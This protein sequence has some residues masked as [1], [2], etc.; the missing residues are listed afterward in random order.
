M[1]RTGV[2]AGAGALFLMSLGGSALA[3]SGP[4]ATPPGSNV[5]APLNMST[6]FQDKPGGIWFDGGLGVNSGS[7]LCFGSS[8]ITSW[9]QAVAS[10]SL[11]TASGT[12]IYNN[13]TGNVGIGTTSP[14]TLLTLE[15]SNAAAGLTLSRTGALTGNWG[16]SIGNSNNT[17][18]FNDNV[19]NATRLVLASN[20]NVGIGTVSPGA[21]A[22]MTGGLTINGTNSTQL[23]IQKNGTTG[24]A[25]NVGDTT[26]GDVNFYDK[27]G[28]TFTRSITLNKGNV[29]IGTANPNLLLTT[30]GAIFSQSTGN[31]AGIY[32]TAGNGSYG[33]LQATNAANN[34]AKNLILQ[35]FGGSVAIGTTNPLRPLEV[36]NAMRFTN[37]SADT[38]DGVIGTA[39]FLAGL[40][41]V[42]INTDG[43]GRKINEW[44]SIIQ[45]E[46]PAGNV[47]PG[48]T[49]INTANFGT[50]R[51]PLVVSEAGGWRGAILLRNSAENNTWNMLV[52]Y[53]TGDGKFV[54]VGNAAVDEF[55]LDQSG[56]VYIPGTLTQGS[57]ERLKKNVAT[58][59]D[60]SGLSAVDK[61][62]PVSF[63]WI[64]PSQASS[65]QLG[66]I[67]QQV[68]T[69]FPG[70]VTRES[71]T[72]YTPDGTL[73]VNY[74][75]LIA[76]LVKSVQELDAKVS[77]QQQE[78]DQL[79]AEVQALQAK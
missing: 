16:I 77:V 43:A 59:D 57:D 11:W 71:S 30:E 2:F 50:A 72:T 41:I 32:M 39:P 38:N 12:N 65:T 19:A 66:F 18:N 7:A 8:C 68:Q 51:A 61:L 49:L 17:L 31:D 55:M 22:G 37:S 4:S 63:N 79:K 76:P 24:L 64:D 70:L 26:A 53:A 78:I 74:N 73:S 9:A 46:N 42:G 35:Q 6:T 3:W 15:G 14:Q 27:V 25:I 47:F 1:S 54:M 20:G 33:A 28:G 36:N 34:V 29:G 21:D 75:G 23:T 52:D 5:A 48:R 60:G 67:A 13:N 44:G 45:N 56:N 40:N 69:V 62:N 58:L 10:S